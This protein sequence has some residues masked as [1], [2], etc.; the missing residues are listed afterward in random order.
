MLIQRGVL[1]DEFGI[2]HSAQTAKCFLAE[3]FRTHV[4][5][6]LANAV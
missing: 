5:F 4:V 2:E 1:A 3:T 6:S